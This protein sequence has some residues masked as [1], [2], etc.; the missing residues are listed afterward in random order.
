MKCIPTRPCV[1]NK[2]KSVARK[3]R[4]EL[5]GMQEGENSVYLCSDKSHRNEDK[6][7][8]FENSFALR[9]NLTI[10]RPPGDGGGWRDGGWGGSHASFGSLVC[11]TP[12]LPADYPSL[13]RGSAGS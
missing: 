5:G 4:L 11:K 13:F 3:G 7:P 1:A 12:A 9:F 8:P 10:S 6:S 2:T